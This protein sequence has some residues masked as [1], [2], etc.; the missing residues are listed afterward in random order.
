MG[1]VVGVA[2]NLDQGGQRLTGG[3]RS[4]MMGS[5]GEGVDVEEVGKNS[6]DRDGEG[7]GMGREGTWGIGR[8]GAG[9]GTQG[10]Q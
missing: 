5:L 7:L 8:R 10:V 4:S 6:G 3:E 2:Q 1:L 9:G